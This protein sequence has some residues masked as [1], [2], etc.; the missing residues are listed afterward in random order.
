M[1]D[2]LHEIATMACLGMGL[3]FVGLGAVLAAFPQL[4]GNP[5]P[6]TETGGAFLLASGLIQ[7]T[8]RGLPPAA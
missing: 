5:Q 8:P 7:W 3:T 6:F 1:K 2:R 4:G